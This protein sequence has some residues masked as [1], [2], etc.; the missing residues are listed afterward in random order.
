VCVCVYIYIYIY[1]LQLDQ[2]YTYVCVYVCIIQF[3]KVR[4]HIY[5]NTAGNS[6]CTFLHVCICVYAYI[7]GHSLSHRHHV[8]LEN[9]THMLTSEVMLSQKML[10]L[11]VV[12]TCIWYMQLVIKPVF[13]LARTWRKGWL[14]AFT[15]G[16]KGRRHAQQTFRMRLLS[17]LRVQAAFRGHLTRERVRQNVIA[18]LDDLRAGRRWGSNIRRSSVIQKRSIMRCVYNEKMMHV[19]VC[20]YEWPMFYVCILQRSDAENFWVEMD[21]RLQ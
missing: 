12:P 13:S 3:D 7:I 6:L 5:V 20:V 16:H 4:K 1:I 19:H 2:A 15:R 18:R 14:L 9:T 10:W 21:P 11:P 8:A 17:A